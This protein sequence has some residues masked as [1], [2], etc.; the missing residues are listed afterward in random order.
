ML[1]DCLDILVNEV[2]FLHKKLVWICVLA[3]THVFKMY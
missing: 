2:V 3:H 1:T